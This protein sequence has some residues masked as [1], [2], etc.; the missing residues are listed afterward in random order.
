MVRYDGWSGVLRS[1]ICLGW[2][3]GLDDNDASHN[4]LWPPPCDRFR[5][6][7]LAPLAEAPSSLAI[8]TRFTINVFK[9]NGEVRERPN[10]AVS[11]T[12]VPFGDR[13]FESHPLRHDINSNMAVCGAVR[14]EPATHRGWDSNRGIAGDVSPA[15]G[16]TRGLAPSVGARTETVSATSNSHHTTLRVNRRVRSNRG[17]ELFC[18][19]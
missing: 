6:P 12:A 2:N 16:D 9:R 3:G 19:Q 17:G 18:L 11:K 10:R 4:P 5:S 15:W 8:S 13:G 1:G 7:Q 14:H